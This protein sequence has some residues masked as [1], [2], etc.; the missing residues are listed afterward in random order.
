MRSGPVPWL[1]PI[2][3]EPLQTI[4]AHAFWRV[5]VSGRSDLP[6]PDLKVHLDRYLALPQEEQRSHFA[7]KKDGQLIGTLRLGAGE[8]SG[9]SMDPRHV[10]DA[11][12][13]LLKGVD[14]LRARDATA[15][16]GHFEDRYSDAFA[17]LGFRRV[18]ARMRMEAPTRKTPLRDL[19]LQPPEEDEVLGLTKFLMEVYDGHME[20]QYGMH[21]GSEEEWRGYLA[22]LLKGDS[23]RFM[24]DASY[25]IL[26]ED[27]IVGS[28]LVTH[29]MGMPLVAELGVAKDRRGRGLGRA[30]LEQSMTRLA[31]LDE[32]RIALYVTLS[33]D[34]A[35]ALYRSLG[36]EQ[37]GGQSVTARLEA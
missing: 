37:V 33:N 2:V 25:V 9:F 32:T 24:P 5:F 1:V 10:D 15:I 29:W 17:S 14:Q 27:R 19:P 20:Q 28:I 34:P 18:F 36:F 21:V 35:I 11:A 26:E 12:A 31:G 13:V 4:D 22:G 16:T 8:I 30:L 23:G 7:A 6:T 3:L